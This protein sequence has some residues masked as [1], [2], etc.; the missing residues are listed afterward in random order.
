MV[1]NCTLCGMGPRATI[2]LVGLLSL[3]FSAGYVLFTTAGVLAH[4][5]VLPMNN[6]I[7]EYAIYVYYLRNAECGKINLTNLGI[8]N[9]PAD[10]QIDVPDVSDAGHRTYIL[11]IVGLVIYGLWFI[12]SLFLLTS[13]CI[14]C[15]G[16]CGIAFGIYP[17]VV[18]LFL[19]LAFDVVGLVYYMIDFVESFELDFV[20]NLLEIGNQDV[21]RPF[22]KDIDDIFLIVPPL[23]FWIT[24]SKGVIIWFIFFLLAFVMLGVGSRLWE[25]NKPA[26]P[27]SSVSPR[28]ATAATA[29]VE[30]VEDTRTVAAVRYTDPARQPNDQLVYSEP[31]PPMTNTTMVVNNN[32]NV[33]RRTVEPLKVGYDQ[34]EPPVYRSNEAPGPLRNTVLNPYTDKRFSYLPGNPQ[35]FSYLAGPPQMSPRNSAKVPEEH[36]Q[37]PR[38]Y[39]PAARD[40]E[41][42][43]RITSTLTESKDFGGQEFRT[44]TSKP[45]SED[46][47]SDEGRWSGP[48][49]RY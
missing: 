44:P 13:A 48:E 10:F 38:S 17:Y 11:C 34:Q 24:A 29:P 37:P 2:V 35:P 21:V 32:N 49:Y 4:N 45:G 25:E 43:K 3:L 8:A 19:V 33:V 39:F 22:F 30:M 46:R 40:W 20:L 23:I 5:C 27:Y 28:T 41:E 47:S 6:S 18:V 7:E 15:L 31:P 16:R 9:V 1:F 26:P 12:T 36:G 14:S 42:P